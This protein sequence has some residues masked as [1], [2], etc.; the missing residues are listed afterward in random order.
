MEEIVN[1]L[2]YPFKKYIDLKMHNKVKHTI[3]IDH[4]DA[5]QNYQHIINIRKDAKI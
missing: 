3:Y 5:Q 4:Q 1:L 2:D